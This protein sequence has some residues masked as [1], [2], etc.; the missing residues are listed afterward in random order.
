MK[1]CRRPE[2]ELDVEAERGMLLV[3]PKLAKLHDGAIRKWIRSYDR[4]A[5]QHAALGIEPHAARGCLTHSVKGTLM[6]LWEFDETAWQAMTKERLRA[7]L[8]RVMKPGDSEM[9]WDRIK[10]LTLG[11][12]TVAGACPPKT[13]FRKSRL[14]QMQAIGWSES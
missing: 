4:Y 2:V 11:S 13:L 8:F 14:V 9:V 12:E 7:G 3:P 10:M 6:G 1:A 5:R